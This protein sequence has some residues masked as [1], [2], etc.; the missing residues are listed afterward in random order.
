[1]GNN[2][3]PIATNSTEKFTTFTLYDKM[4]FYVKEKNLPDI[5]NK[6][7]KRAKKKRTV[8]FQATP[9]P[10]INI[11]NQQGRHNYA[12]GVKLLK[13]TCVVLLCG[14]QGTRLGSD[15]PKGLFYFDRLGKN[16]FDI[17]FDRIRK[18]QNEYKIKVKIFLMTSSFTY[19]DTKEYTDQIKDLDITIFM[20][21][22]VDCLTLD[23]EAYMSNNE[24]I[25]SPN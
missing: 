13:S 10:Q 2:F 21:D 18:I 25:V 11:L 4:D 16:L 8:T 15:K 3:H 5:S 19:N 12:I 22:N 23:K 20:Q 24:N 7:I 17:H 9:A 1:M 6:D 14:G